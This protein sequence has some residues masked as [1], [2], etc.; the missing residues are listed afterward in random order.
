MRSARLRL[1]C[2]AVVAGSEQA[3][4]SLKATAMAA[5]CWIKPRTHAARGW[6][7]GW[8]LKKSPTQP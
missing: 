6:A 2:G 7:D 8:V 1:L 5:G 4:I 3:H